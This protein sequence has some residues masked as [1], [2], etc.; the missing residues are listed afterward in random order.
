MSNIGDSQPEDSEQQHQPSYMTVE[1]PKGIWLVCLLLLLIMSMFFGA[2]KRYFGFEDG[3]QA[4]PALKIFSVGFLLALFLMLHGI[5]YL[6]P[7][8]IKIVI[9]VFAVTALFGAFQ[10]TTGMLQE[11][12]LYLGILVIR[13]IPPVLAIWYLARRPFV[14]LAK[15]YNANREQE[16]M[17]KYIR[18]QLLKR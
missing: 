6:K 2:G 4:T 16:L 15:R 13:V 8:V 3:G 17:N 10:F 9:G 18:K 11:S 7:R 5:I 1:R 14:G 12:K